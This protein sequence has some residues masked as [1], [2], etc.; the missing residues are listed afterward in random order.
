MLM[1]LTLLATITPQLSNLSEWDLDGNGRWNVSNKTLIL[2]KAG[3]TGGPIRRPAALAILRS[4]PF[5]DVTV[6]AQVRSMEP[7]DLLVR[8]VLLIFGYQSPTRFYYVHLSAKTDGV[9]NGIFVVNDADR[10]RIDMPT[11]KPAL[12]DQA[13]HSVRLE[14]NV[15]SGTIEIYVD[16]EK[17]PRLAAKDTTLK[18]GRIGF[19]SFDETGEFRQIEVSVK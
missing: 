16:G 18:S 13:W 5:A 19:G 3:V 4:E 6:R 14:R 17:T 8:D 12:V 10:R 1:I 15:S 2:D 9:H 7:V 11:A